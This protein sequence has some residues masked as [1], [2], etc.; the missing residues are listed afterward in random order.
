MTTA[1]LKNIVSPVNIVFFFYI[2]AT[3]SKA[4]NKAEQYS[5]ALDLLCMLSFL[6]KT[7]ILIKQHSTHSTDVIKHSETCPACS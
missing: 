5:F 7:K 2:V 3:Q 1:Y 4:L 6:N